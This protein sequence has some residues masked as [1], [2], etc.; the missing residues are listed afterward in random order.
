MV[1][2]SHRPPGWGGPNSR[3]LSRAVFRVLKTGFSKK[4]RGTFTNAPEPWD[5][6]VF[7]KRSPKSLNGKIGPFWERMVYSETLLRS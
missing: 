1:G 3:F 5:P 6:G 2:F 7:I 4:P